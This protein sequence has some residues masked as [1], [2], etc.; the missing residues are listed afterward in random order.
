MKTKITQE[1]A[2]RWA[3]QGLTILV[4]L[5]AAVA[6]NLYFKIGEFEATLSQARAESDKASQ[7]AA[8]ARK[9]L[10]DELNA[11]KTKSAALE[12]RQREA[13]NMKALLAKMEPQ[14]AAVLEAVVN[15][16]TSK[17]DARAAALTSLGVI[18]QI[19]RG[20]NN[21][22]ALAAL[23][24]ALGIDKA[25]CVA[26]LAVNLGGAKKIDVAPDCR[27]LLPAAPA[28]S[29]AKPAAE[30][31]PDAAPAGGAAKAALPA[32]KG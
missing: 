21:E 26:G 10:Q 16:K 4:V 15:A 24:R 27:A 19:A 13:D 30:A 5:V 25:N 1:K 32:A 18:G 17:P 31:K 11:A 2:L 3:T 12:Q 8:A 14:L 29:E 6:V 7:A 20:T 23:E 22:A 9:K 28:P